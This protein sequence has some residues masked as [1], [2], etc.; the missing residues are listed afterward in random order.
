MPAA[1]RSEGEQQEPAMA[2]VAA[3]V[4][5]PNPDR[6]ARV[7]AVQRAIGNRAT[8]RLVESTPHRWPAGRSTPTKTS[9]T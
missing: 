3:P 8:A 9:T 2:L 5:A 4:A 6:V 7:R 1:V